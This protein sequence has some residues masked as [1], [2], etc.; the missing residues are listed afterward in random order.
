[1]CACVRASLCAHVCHTAC[2]LVT[3]CARIDARSDG[4][5]DRRMD[6]LSD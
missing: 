3:L 5:T 4:L 1:M 2:V 6:W